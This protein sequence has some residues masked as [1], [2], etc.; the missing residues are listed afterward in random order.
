[1]NVPTTARDFANC[2]HDLDVGGL[3]RHIAARSG[4]DA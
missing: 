3:L 4:G 1:M 2:G